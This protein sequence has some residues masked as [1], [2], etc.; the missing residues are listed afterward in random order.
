[1]IAFKASTM[2]ASWG[3]GS[4]PRCI[5]VSSCHPNGSGGEIWKHQ[6]SQHQMEWF[7]WAI[8]SQNL[9]YLQK[10]SSQHNLQ[11]HLLAIHSFPKRNTK[12]VSLTKHLKNPTKTR[13]PEHPRQLPGQS[14]WY[15]SMP[16][17]QRTTCHPDKTSI[18]PKFPPNLPCLIYRKSINFRNFPQ[19]SMDLI[20][21]KSNVLDGRD[22][23]PLGFYTTILVGWLN[24]PIW[25]ICSSN[26]ML[27]QIFGM[28]S[29]QK[30]K[31]PPWWL[32]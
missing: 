26:W 1:M 9:K 18:F 7:H 13:S 24:Q 14:V 23:C 28:N 12:Q 15:P 22:F 8:W 19:V 16:N 25:Q 31:P 11:I 27:S 5:S 2:N 30:M 32:L 10:A 4:G 6:F 29:L 3:F 17:V 21:P 20:Y